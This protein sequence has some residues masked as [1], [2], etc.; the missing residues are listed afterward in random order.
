[1]N[2]E[3]HVL[4]IQRLLRESIE[5]SETLNRPLKRSFLKGLSDFY[6]ERGFL[7]KKQENSLEE[8]WAELWELQADLKQKK[9]IRYEYADDET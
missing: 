8:V 5:I 6:K 4:L 7:S 2:D 9:P 3:E 1:M